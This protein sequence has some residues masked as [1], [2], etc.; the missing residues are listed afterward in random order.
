MQRVSKP[1]DL[2]RRTTAR[3]RIEIEQRGAAFVGSAPI[4][5]LEFDNKKPVCERP[6]MSVILPYG[7]LAGWSASR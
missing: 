5:A 7:L 2:H 1:N 6:L 4:T 3:G